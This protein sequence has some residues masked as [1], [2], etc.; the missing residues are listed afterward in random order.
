MNTITEQINWRVSKARDMKWGEP[1]IQ[2]KYG[3]ITQYDD[4][5]LDVWATT[6]RTAAKLEKIWTPKK[7][8]DDG[9]MF[10]RPFADL[11]QAC[12]IL[13]ARKRRKVSSEMIKRGKKLADRQRA[14]KLG[15]A[16]GSAS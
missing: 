13:K 16:A 5:D 2:C 12:L 4:G 10:I 3:I 1:Y 15:L 6:T 14:I 11:D 7:H 9:A 8:Y